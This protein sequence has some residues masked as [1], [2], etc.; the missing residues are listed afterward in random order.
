[1]TTEEG[2]E[3]IEHVTAGLFEQFRMEREENRQL[4]RNSQ[5][6]IDALGEKIDR[7][8]EE[9]RAEDKLLGE[10]IHR[11]AEDSRAA[12]Q[13]LKERIDGLVS[14]IG[15]MAAESYAEQQR[16]AQAAAE[17]DKRL[18][19][20]INQSRQESIEADKRWQAQINQSRQELIE[21]DQRW[22]AQINPKAGRS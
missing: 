22:Q 21:A 17:A 19:A 2:F 13:Y 18:E 8:A 1:M 4:W 14:A 3:R 6:Q 9:A 15:Q 12:D 5:R 16:R 20:Q 7:L 11:M 10:Q